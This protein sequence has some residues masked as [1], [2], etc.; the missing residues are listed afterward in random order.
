[1]AAL[2]TILKAAHEAGLSPGSLRL[3]ERLGLLSPQRDSLGRRLYTASDV[4]QARRVAVERAA[5]CGRGLR[6][7]RSAEVAA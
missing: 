6:G 5:K 2:M 1:M 3:Y 4:L 7:T